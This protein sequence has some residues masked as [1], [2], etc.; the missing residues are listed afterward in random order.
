MCQ[1]FQTEIF[2]PIKYVWGVKRIV[3]GASTYNNLIPC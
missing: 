3:R 1:E 2:F